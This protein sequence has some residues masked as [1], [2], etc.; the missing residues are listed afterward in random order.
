M[1]LAQEREARRQEDARCLTQA[2]AV[3]R[4]REAGA[5]VETGAHSDAEAAAADG[6]ED[7]DL[8]GCCRLFSRALRAPV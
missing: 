5:G 8:A 7:D 1:R 4:L 3:Y 6:T 2:R